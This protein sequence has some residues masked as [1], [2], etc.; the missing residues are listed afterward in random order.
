MKCGVQ[1]EIK[2]CVE[3]YDEEE[4]KVG[5]YDCFA[6]NVVVRVE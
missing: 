3:K 2:Q 4:L 6:Y 1:C 5:I